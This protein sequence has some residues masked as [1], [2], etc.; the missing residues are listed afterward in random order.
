MNDFATVKNVE[1]GFKAAS[2]RIGS[3]ETDV[4]E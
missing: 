3:V 1:T 2:E 4:N